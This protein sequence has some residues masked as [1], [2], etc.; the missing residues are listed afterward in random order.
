V[1]DLH[2]RLASLLIEQSHNI[3]TARP[4]DLLDMEAMSL[5]PD[6]M[7]FI[8]ESLNSTIDEDERERTDRLFFGCL[9]LIM[10][11]AV[12]TLTDMRRFYMEKGR[13]LVGDR[14]IPANDVVNWLQLQSDFNK[15]E[16]ILSEHSIFHKGII[17]P[18]LLAI[19]DVQ[20]ETV[21]DYEFDNLIHYATQK[22]RVDFMARLGDFAEFLQNTEDEYY[23][24]MTP[25]VE[26]EIGKPFHKLSRCHA[27]R[28]LRVRKY[29]DRFGTE[30]TL[31]K[32][33]RTFSGIGFDPLRREDVVVDFS[34]TNASGMCVGLAIPGESHVL[35]NPVGGLLDMETALHETGHAFFLS[36][37]DP[38]LPMEFRRLYRTA[39]L[40]E[41]FAFLFSGLLES[42]EWLTE[43]GGL[44][45][46]QALNLSELYQTRKLCLIR[47]YI[48]KLQAETALHKS[49]DFKNPEYYTDFMEKAT[50]F[51]YEPAGYLADMEPGF[52]SVDYLEG[53][54]G[55]DV[56]TSTLKRL[57]GPAWFRSTSVGDFL[58]DL[59]RNGRKLSATELL[60]RR[61]D[62]SLRLPVP[63]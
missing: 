52:Y 25:W 42:P 13:M 17:N 12:A 43:I 60:E 26:T 19:L 14:K 37:F 22:K 56:L 61:C 48:G 31:D 1:E 55:A 50:G 4:S 41:A 7:R 30:A 15:R 40:D 63:H 21:Q 9:D 18:L 24:R 34:A 10:E 6:T 62:A 47:R 28:L 51:V 3:I 2:R 32:L 49:G 20:L 44:T 35:M 39:G 36:N 57:F 29:D 33:A 46:S 5:G 59:A 11:G 54:A 8:R 45:D 23:R 27:L 53:W 38:E 58:I 16:E